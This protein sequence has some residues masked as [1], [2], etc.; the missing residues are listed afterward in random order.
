MQNFRE[1]Y[2]IAANKNP[3]RAVLTLFLIMNLILVIGGAATI[4]LLAPESLQHRGFLPFVYY[5]INLIL[6]HGNIAL[7]VEDIGKVSI[8]CIT[9]CVFVIVAGMIIFYR[10][11]Y[12]IRYKLYL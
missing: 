10:C 4:S 1:A 12:W 8:A 11:N 5:T 2:S 7:V 6:D 3:Q 9:V